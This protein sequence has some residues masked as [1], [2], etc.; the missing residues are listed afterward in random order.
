MAI[1]K[2]DIYICSLNLIYSTQFAIF[3]QKKIVSNLVMK[4]V[5]P[6]TNLELT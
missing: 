2:G 1:K 3:Y 6:S 4:V 5:D